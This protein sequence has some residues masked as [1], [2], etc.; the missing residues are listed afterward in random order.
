MW[1][2]SGMVTLLR[3]GGMWAM[4]CC[5]VVI[6]STC[7]TGRGSAGGARI[8]VVCPKGLPAEEAADGRRLMDCR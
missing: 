1:T 5:W 4:N 8:E 2:G 3:K 6:H 7:G